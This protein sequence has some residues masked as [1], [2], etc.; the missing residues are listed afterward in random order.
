LSFLIPR[1]LAAPVIVMVIAVQV[2]SARVATALGRTVRRRRLRRRAPAHASRSAAAALDDWHLP[3][4]PSRFLTH[5]A[6]GMPP[7]PAIIRRAHRAG[8]A[9][10]ASPPAT[11]ERTASHGSG[12]ISGQTLCFFFFLFIVVGAT[13]LI[14]SVARTGSHHQRHQSR[15]R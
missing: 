1:G 6:T 8:R 12:D 11:S 5:A 7:R 14:R 9:V 15:S 2:Y 13:G 4:H 3:L 10:P